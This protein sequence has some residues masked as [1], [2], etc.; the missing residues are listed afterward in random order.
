MF[1]IKRT[2]QN[3]LKDFLLACYNNIK[4]FL[5]ILEPLRAPFN[6]SISVQH[7]E[8]TTACVEILVLCLIMVK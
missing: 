3:L 2:F 6:P 5:G 4:L 8:Q 7:V 1:V